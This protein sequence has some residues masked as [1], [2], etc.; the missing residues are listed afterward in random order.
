MERRTSIFVLAG[1]EGSVR[2]V[3]S[4]EMLG[5]KRK[6]GHGS[7]DIKMMKQEEST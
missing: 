2:L 5:I 3:R 6:T 1:I 4:R 7:L